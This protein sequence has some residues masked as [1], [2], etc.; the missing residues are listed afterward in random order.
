[1]HQT[2]DKILFTQKIIQFIYITIFFE[3]INIFPF[4]WKPINYWVAFD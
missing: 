2:L 1:M 3:N 4:Y